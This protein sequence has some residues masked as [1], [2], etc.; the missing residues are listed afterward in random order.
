[1][2]SKNVNDESS[3]VEH[4]TH[5]QQAII[6]KINKMGH[7]EMCSLWRYA[8]IGHPYF[9]KRLPYYKIYHERLFKHFGG[10]TPEISKSLG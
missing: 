4:Y 1:M 9:D 8:P 2:N 10:F 3:R 5:E 6:D 7:Y